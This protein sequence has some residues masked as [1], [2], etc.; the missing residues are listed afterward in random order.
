MKSFQ[1]CTV[2]ASSAAPGASAGF[3]GCSIARN[4]GTRYAG[5]V[6]EAGAV[7]EVEPQRAGRICPPSAREG[8]VGAPEEPLPALLALATGK[9]K[10]REAETVWM[11][12]V[13]TRCAGDVEAVGNLRAS[14]TVGVGRGGARALDLLACG[15]RCGA[16]GADS[17]AGVSGVSASVGT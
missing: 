7:G 2:E 13:T 9:L 12:R 4:A 6:A 11:G 16:G 5:A 1:Q 14:T 8:G 3:F 10:S 15:A 17:R